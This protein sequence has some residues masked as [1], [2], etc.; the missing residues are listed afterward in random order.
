MTERRSMMAERDTT[1]RYLAAFLA[2]RV[3]AE[4]AGTIAGIAR[5]GLFVKLDETGADGLVPISSLGSEYF[6]HDPDTQTLTGERSRRV[7]GLGQRVTGAARR[8]GADH[9]R[10]ALRAA[11]GRGP[12]DADAAAP[13]RPGRPA[14]QA[15]AAPDQARQGRPPRPAVLSG[16]AAA[17]MV[18]DQSGVRVQ[19]P[20]RSG[21]GGRRWQ[22]LR[23]GRGVPATPGRSRSI[24]RG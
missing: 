8:G 23:P 18:V 21:F 5:F 13:R 4:F 10:A 15:R 17:T 19:G 6:R 1:D 16:A 22:K 3:G 11:R 2:D 9:R 14:A 12:P 20:A 24:P 7:I